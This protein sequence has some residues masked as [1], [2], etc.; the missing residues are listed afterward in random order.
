[1][2]LHLGVKSDPIENRYTFEWLFDLLRGLGV[3]HVQMGSSYPT[4][5][6]ED[7]WFL[8]LRAQ[9]EKRDVHI[10]SVFTTHRELGGFASGDPVLEAGARKG[11]ERLIHVASLVGAGSAGSNTGIVM[12]DQPH[13]RESGIRRF[14]EQGRSLL[15]IARRAGLS[16]LAIEPMSSVWE[17]PSTPDEVAALMADF[18]PY[19]AA[20]PES[21]VPLLLCADIS[22]GVADA[23][24]RVVHDN[25]SLFERE[26]PWMWEFHFKNTDA[27]FDSTFGFSP[28]ERER[29]IVDL[30][31]L[32]GLID[33]NT[34]RFPAPDVIG[35]LEIGGPKLGRE[36]A[37]RH[38]ER[39]LVDS[40]QALKAVFFNG[41]ETTP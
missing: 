18:A 16:A 34:D 19:H 15:G 20:N 27:I 7:S 28:K 32:K 40:I 13:L 4:F 10:S 30:H 26:I 23:E 25:W 1:M 41:K 39:M 31:R 21:T 29:G 14:S 36:Y 6:A 33:A 2:K 5:S 22:H 11:W 37:D 38:L 9:A 24:G 3:H 17:Y 12:R 8:R 35:Y